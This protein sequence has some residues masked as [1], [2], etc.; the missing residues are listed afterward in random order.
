M[1][2]L[3]FAVLMIFVAG[4]ALL[5]PLAYA[6][7]E[8][9]AVWF[10]EDAPRFTEEQ[11]AAIERLNDEF[12][13]IVEPVFRRD[14]RYPQYLAD[15]EELKRITDPRVFAEK[16]AAFEANWSAFQL[17]VMRIAGVT[18]RDYN[19]RLQKILP[20]LRLDENGRIINGDPDTRLARSNRRK[21]GAF[22]KDPVFFLKATEQTFETTDFSEKWSFKDC[23][24][25]IVEFPTSKSFD[26]TAG[27]DMFEQDCEDVKAARGT[28][29][30]VPSGVIKVKVEIFLD[31]YTLRAHAAAY[32]IFGYANAYAAVGIRVRGM[33]AGSSKLVNY[34]RHKYYD[35]SW[36]VFGH[37]LEWTSETG[38]RMVKSFIPITPGEYTIQAY[39]RVA[40]D[41]DG[42]AY[43]GTHSG[44]EGLKKIRVTFFK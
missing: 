27:T 22:Q 44:V 4:S 1:K 17:E 40:V 41:S 37:D 13:A 16:T 31:E 38:V 29:I 34:F 25:A 12:N 8:T 35:V 43:S 2:S 20:H 15:L 39:S 30:N 32:G 3:F 9:E 33:I 6:R 36:S 18:E 28:I 10:D 26:V 5:S 7:E 21:L 24:Q 11:R 42:F 23:V 14:R 19:L